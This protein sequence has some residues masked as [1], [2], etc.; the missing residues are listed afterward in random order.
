MAKKPKMTKVD[1]A[2]VQRPARSGGPK[3]GNQMSAF[4]S[5]RREVDRAEKIVANPKGKNVTPKQVAKAKA[6]LAARKGPAGTKF[7]AARRRS[8]ETKDFGTIKQSEFA[9]Q[10]TKSLQSQARA[11]DSGTQKMG[12]MSEA[13]LRAELKRREQGDIREQM[14]KNPAGA[15]HVMSQSKNATVKAAAGRVNSKVS[16]RE[17][18]VREMNAQTDAARRGPPEGPTREV[19]DKAARTERSVDPG[20]M[21]EQNNP[22]AGTA[23]IKR[24]NAKASLKAAEKAEARG[25]TELAQKLRQEA[26]RYEGEAKSLTDPNRGKQ[27]ASM[28]DAVAEEG[29]LRPSG[30]EGR[31]WDAARREEEEALRHWGNGSEKGLEE[32][33]AREEAKLAEE[34]AALARADQHRDPEAERNFRESRIQEHEDQVE[35]MR[36]AQKKV[37]EARE[38]RRRL[39]KEALRKR[40]G[41]S[42]DDQPRVPAGNPDGGQW[43]EG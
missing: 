21:N 23:A 42:G 1:M 22:N 5:R 2:K 43:T 28:E 11:L 29:R 30:E 15:A 41:G 25:E 31:A 6:T 17:A 4:E 8:A 40:R 20:Q 24:A 33:I 32:N 26:D 37:A 16:P 12:G 10:S 38:R 14:M 7:E 13:N 27:V 9:K 35:S 34:R 36:L 18:V 19:R 3:L 39:S